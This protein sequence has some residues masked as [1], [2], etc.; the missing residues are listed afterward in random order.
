MCSYHPSIDSL[1]SDLEIR[2]H[3][4]TET[5]RLEAQVLLAHVL[6]QTRSWI[7][8][9][10]EVILTLEQSKELAQA[11][12]RLQTGEPLPY[13]LGHWEFFG[14][15]FL[16]SPDVLIPR[17]ETELLIE[18]A[19]EWLRKNPDRKRVADIGT[20]SGCIA[21]T[22]ASRISNLQLVASDVSSNALK[23]AE[24]NAH[25]HA[26]HDR[27]TFIQADLLA[28]TPSAPFDLLC[29]N[30]PYIPTSRLSTLSVSKWEPILA[31]DGGADGTELINRLISSAP[32]YV[33]SGGLLLLEIDASQAS[34]LQPLAQA[35]FPD[36]H[37]RI[38]C[39]SAGLARLFE[40][41]L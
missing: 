12:S 41:Q 28:F 26:V 19:I 9:H 13:V 2:F 27:I 34:I 31:L 14:L 5:P 10:P 20:G 29:A 25:R 40:I 6:N 11:V 8:A 22:L 38:H 35:T 39:D 36:A 37:L 21:I 17:P 30:L 4:I 3:P 33:A 15:D 16:V 7:L 23:I 32:S 18:H 1:L 24:S